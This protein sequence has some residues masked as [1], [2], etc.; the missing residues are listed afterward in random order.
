M[1]TFKPERRPTVIPRL[2]TRD[3]AA[4]VAFMREVFDARGELHEG[5]P[6]ELQ[7][8]SSVVMVSDGGGV[9]A[10]NASCL[11]VYVPDVDAAFSR[12]MAAGA[13]SVEPPEDMPWGDRRA[14][15]RDAWGNDWQLA[16]HRG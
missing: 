6:T 16:T 14:S 11:Y 10:P 4:L 2:F 3:V 7:I 15:I 13:T 1:S 12:A 5:R 8:G 9:R